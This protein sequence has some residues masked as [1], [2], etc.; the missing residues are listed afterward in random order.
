MTKLEKFEQR[1]Q[2]FANKVARSL[3]ESALR[4]PESSAE[5]AENFKSADQVIDEAR[6]ACDAAIAVAAK[7]TT[8]R[9][10]K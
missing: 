10:G 9:E 6:H 2:T 3:R 8:A 4:L 7:G 5:R 1:H